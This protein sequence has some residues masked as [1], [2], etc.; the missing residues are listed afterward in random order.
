MR[1]TPA[2]RVARRAAALERRI[3]LRAFA[4]KRG[5]FKRATYGAA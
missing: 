2:R 3:E 5:S 4:D 1:F